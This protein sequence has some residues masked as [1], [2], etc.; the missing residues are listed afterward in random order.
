M[1]QDPKPIIKSILLTDNTVARR[2]DEM[3]AEQLSSI[4]QKTPF[5]MQLDETTLP[6]NQAL[7]L[8]YVRYVTEGQQNEEFLFAPFS[9]WT[10]KGT[11][12]SPFRLGIPAIGECFRPHDASMVYQ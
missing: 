11:L 5:A 9:Q 8:A 4:L 10:P 6:D 12:G 3:A 1:Q 2:T 7:L